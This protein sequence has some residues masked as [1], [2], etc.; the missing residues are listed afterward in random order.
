MADT[1]LAAGLTQ[2]K[3][4]D[5]AF[6]KDQFLAGARAAFEMVVAAFAAGDTKS[7]RPL[8]ANDVY[9][10]FA[11]AIKERE[12]AKQNLDTPL[13]AITTAALLAADLRQ[14]TAF[15]T[16]KFVTAPCNAKHDARREP[17]GSVT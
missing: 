6:D 8:L 12:E 11:G 13:I 2:V 3:L 9:D 16:L 5:R 1:P 15:L 10:V 4:A 17:V 14:K 7:L